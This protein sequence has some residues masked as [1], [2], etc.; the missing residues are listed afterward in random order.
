LGASILAIFSLTGSLPAQEQTE[1]E[2]LRARI[3]RLEKQNEKLLRAVEGKQ[4]AA[5]EPAATT[6]GAARKRPPT[7]SPGRTRRSG[8]T[9]RATSSATTWA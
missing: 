6:D 3:E 1:I 9:R 2:Q 8:P 5:P 7:A 4:P